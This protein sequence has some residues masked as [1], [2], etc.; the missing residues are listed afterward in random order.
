MERQLLYF[1]DFDLRFDEEEACIHF[2]PFL[3]VREPCK[4]HVTPDQETRAA[5]VD[6]VSKAGRARAQAQLPPTPPHQA[7]S[8]HSSS[9]LA[10]TVRSLARRL[11]SNTIGS[12]T[13]RTD[14]PNCSP[15]STFSSTSRTSSNLS[16]KSSAMGSLIY[17]SGSSSS[18][19][20]LLERELDDEDRTTTKFSLRPIPE[21]AYREGRK[22]S[23]TS[24][25][26]STTTVREESHISP[27]G[28]IRRIAFELPRQNLVGSRTIS[29]SSAHLDYAMNDV[30]LTERSPSMRRIKESLSMGHASG[31]FL[32]RMWGAATKAQDGNMGS[33]SAV[34]IVEPKESYPH[35]HGASA[36]RRLVHSRST[37]FRT[38]D[39]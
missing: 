31:N 1:L 4:T 37:V 10:S 35:M 34:G 12:L 5:A 8:N 3:T 27:R 19:D 7:P 36:F 32:S 38:G 25:I 28:G 16:R 14:V 6:R 33:A 24:S 29:H 39:T 17:D 30:T 23:E 22:V 20:S 9:T 13:V 2:A 26:A 21:S 15:K 11:S 18:T